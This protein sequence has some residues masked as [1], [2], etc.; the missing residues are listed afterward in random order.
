M[1]TDSRHDISLHLCWYCNIYAYVIHNVVVVVD[2]SLLLTVNTERKEVL[3][4]AVIT[5]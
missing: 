5:M 1:R 3:N 4:F 2:N